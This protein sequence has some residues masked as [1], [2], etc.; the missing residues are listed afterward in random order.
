M[1]NMSTNYRII[2]FFATFLWQITSMIAN[3]CRSLCKVL[4]FCAQKVY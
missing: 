1:L 3:V 2:S 4:V